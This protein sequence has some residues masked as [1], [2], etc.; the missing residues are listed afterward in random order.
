MLLFSPLLTCHALGFLTSQTFLACILDMHFKIPF[1]FENFV[2]YIRIA[3]AVFSR[4]PAVAQRDRWLL[5][6]AGTQVQPPA[7]H[8][9]LRIGIR[10]CCSWMTSAQIEF[11]VQ[12]LHMPQGS[13]KEKNIFVTPI[14]QI[15]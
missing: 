3:K 4:V 14:T 11:L 10:F 6:N 2:K 13:Q 1:H 15:Q 9:G 12:K 5:W 8:S 7:R